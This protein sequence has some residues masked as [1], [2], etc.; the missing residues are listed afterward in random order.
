MAYVGVELMRVKVPGP[1]P[2]EPPTSVEFATP[3]GVP[4][5]DQGLAA[6]D[7]GLDVRYLIPVECQGERRPRVRDA[8]L[9][10]LML[11]GACAL[12]SIRSRGSF[13]VGRVPLDGPV[14]VQRTARDDVG[15]L[16]ALH[17]P[18]H[19][20]AALEADGELPDAGVR[21]GAGD[22]VARGD[23]GGVP[24]RDRPGVRRDVGQRRLSPR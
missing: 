24:V 1:R 16:G 22:R 12:S 19:L 4:V 21:V 9:V 14:H 6:H 15:L 13:A 23:D 20:G 5:P 2:P 10:T 8:A 17:R 7:L 3:P 18:V 11:I